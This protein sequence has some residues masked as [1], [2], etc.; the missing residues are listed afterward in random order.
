MDLAR[1]FWLL[2]LSLAE[3]SSNNLEAEAGPL[4]A[5]LI[6]SQCPFP[7]SAHVMSQGRQPS[8]QCLG[9]AKSH[10]IS[11]ACEGLILVIDGEL[12]SLLLHTSGGMQHG[13]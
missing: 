1:D 8:G 11:S 6:S 2:F 5:T 4:T 12:A 7:G 13:P 9:C 10:A 3:S